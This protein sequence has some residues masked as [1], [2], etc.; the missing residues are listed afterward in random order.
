M[1]ILADSFVGVMFSIGRSKLALPVQ[2]SFLLLNALGVL[3]GTIYNVNT[4]DL[5]ENN[6]HHK[7]GWIAT[8]VFI[9]QVVM[10][11][12]FVCSG[13][14]KQ[15]PTTSS[16]RAAFLPPALHSLNRPSHKH[17]W[18]GDSG[19]G[20]E[21]SSPTTSSRTRS[22]SRS[23]EFD[24]EVQEEPEDMEEIPIEPVRR[25]PSWFKNTKIDEYLSRRAHKV[26]SLKVIKITEITYELI[27][28]AILILG[29]ITITSGIVTY[30]GIFRAANVFNGLAHFVK[31]GIFLWYGLLTLGR[32]LGSFADLGWAW[33]LKPTTS[34]VGW[35]ARVPT[36]EFVESFVIF[37]YGCTTVFMEHLA[38]WGNEWVAQDFEHVSISVM[39]FGGG[40]VSSSQWN[41]K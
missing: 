35:K 34:E 29:F 21:P 17:S 36:A 40:L 38:A 23:Y 2:L 9:A 14:K 18:S 24:K 11:L 41:S 19:Q 15:E 27:D 25:R 4:P 7:V 37:L 31:G 3:C 26:A 28:R 1:A 30:A 33:N 8:W 16:E 20:T 13:R 22:P 32:W 39:F 12:L 10:S 6:A 5:Y